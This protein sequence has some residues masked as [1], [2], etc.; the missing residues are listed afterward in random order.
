MKAPPVPMNNWGAPPAAA[1]MAPP[2]PRA[3][4]GKAGSAPS[5]PSSQGGRPSKPNL[6]PLDLNNLDKKKVNNSSF[7]VSSG[8]MAFILHNVL[9]SFP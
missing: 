9:Y 6:A 2:V 5:R 4:P 3:P 8:W 7:E 1:S